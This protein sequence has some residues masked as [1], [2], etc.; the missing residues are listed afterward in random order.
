MT[1]KA[2]IEITRRRF[3]LGLGLTGAGGSDGFIHCDAV[4][5]EAAGGNGAGS[6][7]MGLPQA[8]QVSTRMPSKAYPQEG[9]VIIPP[10]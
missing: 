3:R 6:L 1:M 4:G 10:H 2:M 8:G 9:Q 7:E 5:D